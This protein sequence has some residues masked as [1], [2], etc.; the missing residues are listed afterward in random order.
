MSYERRAVDDIP[1]ADSAGRREREETAR[2][3]RPARE[4]YEFLLL[5]LRRPFARPFAEGARA[6]EQRVYRKKKRR[7]AETGRSSE[8]VVGSEDGVGQCDK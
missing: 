3:V 5:D 8:A 7:E 1:V 4:N 2:N 6:S